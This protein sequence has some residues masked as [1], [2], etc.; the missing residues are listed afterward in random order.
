M[1]EFDAF[2]LGDLEEDTELIPII[3]SED[4]ERFS[5]EDIPDILPI[6]PLRNTVLFPGLVIPI[7]VGRE[8]EADPIDKTEF[9][10]EI[11][12]IIADF[13]QITLTLIIIS[14]TS[15]G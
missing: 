1:N 15:G 14:N 13:L 12:S 8:K 5:K 7:T 2:T 9:A 11:A 3:T 10:K 4:E 6:L